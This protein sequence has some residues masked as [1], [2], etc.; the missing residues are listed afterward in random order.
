MDSDR[1]RKIRYMPVFVG[2]DDGDK[3][4]KIVLYREVLYDDERV[5]GLSFGEQL[6]I[7]VGD[8]EL[9]ALSP[10]SDVTMWNTIG[11]DF[12]H[13]EVASSQWRGTASGTKAELIEEEMIG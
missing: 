6:H 11:I 4:T 5:F 10:G 9:W 1:M 7:K 2:K 12:L 3:T 8:G 13:I